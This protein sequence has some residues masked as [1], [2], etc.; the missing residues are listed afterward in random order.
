MSNLS[1]ALST[2]PNPP[3]KER[4]AFS[5]SRASKVKAGLFS[6]T[7]KVSRSS[8]QLMTAASDVL[9]KHPKSKTGELSP[10]AMVLCKNRPEGFSSSST[11]SGGLPTQCFFD[12]ILVPLP[13][14]ILLFALAIFTLLL[15]SSLSL[16]V[17]PPR[18]WPARRHWML[19]YL[20]GVYY[21]D[22]F[23]IVAMQSIEIGRLDAAQLGVGLLPFVYVGCAVAALMRGT[24]GL[25]GYV[26]GASAGCLLF[27]LLSMCVMVVKVVALARF[28][29]HGSLARTGSAYPV[30]DQITD[31]AVMVPFY[32]LLVGMEAWGLFWPWARS[33]A[34]MTLLGEQTEMKQPGPSGA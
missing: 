18:A 15:P 2:S 31:L 21:F 8:Q 25:W 13:T 1:L 29:T 20:D 10:I 7:E 12:T 6:E 16:A 33:E 4:L 32:A 26:T 27:W 34:S 9:S 11:I 3:S 24:R 28:G 23:V 30:P 5:G 14:W 17:R 22:I 19:R